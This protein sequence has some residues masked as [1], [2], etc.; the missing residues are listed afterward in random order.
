MKLTDK[1][2]Q[3][4]KDQILVINSDTTED[5]KAMTD[6]EMAYIWRKRMVE[7][8]LWIVLV[9]AGNMWYQYSFIVNPKTFT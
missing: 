7:A 6:Q 3:G 8:C 5:E 9:S 1:E 2:K 4:L